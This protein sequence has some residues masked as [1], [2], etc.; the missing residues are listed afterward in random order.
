MVSHWEDGDICLNELFYN[1][2]M[3]FTYLAAFVLTYDRRQ[4][5]DSLFCTCT[6]I[7]VRAS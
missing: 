6:A 1:V 5:Q 7:A 4:S 2:G 3:F